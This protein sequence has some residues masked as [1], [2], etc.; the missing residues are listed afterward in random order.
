[1][2]NS[3]L[4]TLFVISFFRILNEFIKL[5]VFVNKISAHRHICIDI[6]LDNFHPDQLEV[7]CFGFSALIPL[8]AELSHCELFPTKLYTQRLFINANHPIH[9]DPI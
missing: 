1:M 6:N 4:Q 9:S 3:C 5:I 2:L 8:V 7:L